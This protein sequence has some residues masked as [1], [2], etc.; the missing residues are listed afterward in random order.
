MIPR[1]VEP[2]LRDALADRPVV[3]LTG[4]RQSGKT[5][6]AKTL[7][8][9][10]YFTLDDATVLGAAA[11]DPEG[12]LDGAGAAVTIDEIQ[13][14]PELLLAIKAS[15]DRQRTKGRFLLTGSADILAVPRIADALPGRAELMTLWPLSN[16]E[17]EG[18][19]GGFVDAIFSDVLPAGELEPVSVGELARLVGR[20]GFPEVVTSVRRT[21]Q[22]FESYIDTILRRDVRDL[23]RIEGLRTLPSLMA[24]IASRPMSLLNYADVARD[25][26]LP[27]T[28]LKRYMALLEAT[29]MI[30]LL[31]PWF[32]SRGKRLVK[33]PKVMLCDTGLA[34]HLQRV[35]TDAIA[36][37]GE[38]F[39]PLLENFV[40]MEIRKQLGWSS[41]DADVWHFRTSD[42]RE[43]DLVLEDRKGRIVG[44][45]VKASST[46]RERD[47]RGM[48]ALA[49][50]AGRKFHR[51]V[52]LYTGRR[53][54]PFA[55]NTHAIPI[56]ALW[57]F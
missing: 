20:G 26:G 9:R 35:D 51:G 14:V 52:I 28:T 45:E 15:V 39:G 56:S 54:V 38:T 21:A 49:G 48:R 3:F 7:A 31:P 4:P 36:G 27:Q 50:I 11:A 44:I 32:R 47:L 22:W 6:L 46:V 16:S 12:F 1:R 5:T 25:A 13:R 17:I 40:A 33:S 37:S 55:A 34:A 42:G 19:A 53:V 18:T 41:V 23:A 8:G 24:V 43:V 2:V 29:F 30:R 57:T 10:Q